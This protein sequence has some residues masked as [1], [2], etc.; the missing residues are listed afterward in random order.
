MNEKEFQEQFSDIIEE[1][2]MSW[3]SHKRDFFLRELQ[4]LLKEYFSRS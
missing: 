3:E 4:E 2:K 1:L